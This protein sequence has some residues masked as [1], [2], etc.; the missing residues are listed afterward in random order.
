MKVDALCNAERRMNYYARAIEIPT[1][2]WTA[3]D[4]KRFN[5]ELPEPAPRVNQERAYTSPIWVHAGNLG[6]VGLITREAPMK[7]MSRLETIS[8]AV[9]AVLTLFALSACTTTGG[10]SGQTPDRAWTIA[11]RTLP[12]PAGASDA[13]RA[14]IANTPQPNVAETYP[15]Y[16]L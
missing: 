5:V 1:P 11:S 12:A 15:K 14:A 6:S 8:K 13:L 2:H 9:L 4:A 16:H 7:P 3:Y 10:G